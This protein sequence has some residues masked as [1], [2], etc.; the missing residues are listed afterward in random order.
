MQPKTILTSFLIFSVLYLLLPFFGFDAISWFLKPFLI[1]FL[2]VSVLITKDF[3]TK[4][5]LLFALFFSWI[6]DIILMFA[7]KGELYFILG[8]VAFL[9]SHLWYIVLFIQQDQ[10]EKTESS[11]KIA[12][13]TTLLL[14]YF[15]GILLLLFPKLG[16]L[17][18]PVVIYAIVITLMLFVAFKNSLRWSNPAA[19]IILLGAISFVLSDSILAINKFYEALPYSNTLI[20]STYILAQYGIVSGVLLLN[21]K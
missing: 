17:K 16:P 8:L 10:N 19:R 21:K 15:F 11:S 1:P 4:K 20:M 7:D 5:I 13:G 14:A 9:V 18:L 3:K 2:I 12:I 6:G